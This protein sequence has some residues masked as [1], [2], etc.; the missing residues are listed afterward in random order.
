VRHC[1]RH[2]FHIA[3]Y[4][5][6]SSDQFYRRFSRQFEIFKRTWNVDG[7]LSVPDAASPFPRWSISTRGTNWTSETTFELLDW[8]DLISRDAERPLGVRLARTAVTYLNLLFTGTLWRYLLANARYFAF[9]VV[10]PLQAMALGVAATLIAAYAAAALAEATA[11]RCVVTVL[12]A[13]V[14]FV[15]F[16]KLAG[17]RWRMFQAF[18]DWILSLDYIRGT[19]R[20]LDDKINQFAAQIVACARSD[21]PDEIVVVG[22]SL[23]ATFAVDALARALNLDPALAT[24]RAKICLVTVGAT[25]PKCALHPAADRLREQ[26]AKVVAEPA[27]LWAEYQARED[28]ISFYRF[29]PVSLTRIGGKAD[30]FDSKPIIRRINVKNLLS[31]E[32]YKRFRLRVLRLHYQFVSANDIRAVYDY[33]MMI[34]GPVLATAWTT[35]RLGFL[36]FFPA[37]DSS[38]VEP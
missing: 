25:I 18:D 15:V 11:I 20:D 37:A 16:L 5:P 9:S 19:R 26:I 3:G 30:R 32:I 21:Q 4:D 36:D 28:A 8:N 7:A 22:H 33:F 38:T 17:P 27:V 34:C 10:P 6:A 35:S 31:P 13:L 24:H 2:V 12:A 23:G 1:K 29:D 14:L